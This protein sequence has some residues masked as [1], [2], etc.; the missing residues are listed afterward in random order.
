MVALPALAEQR[1]IGAALLVLDE[2]ITAHQE[3][4][5]AV[6]RVRAELAEHLMDGALILLSLS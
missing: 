6:D 3:F 4:A 2:Q 1:Q 5:Q